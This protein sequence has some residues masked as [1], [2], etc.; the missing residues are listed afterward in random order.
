MDS[1]QVKQALS[2][3][4]EFAQQIVANYER[5][6]LKP[7][8]SQFADDLIKAAQEQPDLIT[9]GDLILGLISP[10]VAGLDTVASIVLFMLYEII[11][12]PALHAR[13]KPE[14]EA[15]FANG[16]PNA[17]QLRQVPILRSGEDQG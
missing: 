9:Q 2:R 1:P 6:E 17:D 14:T 15:L 12:N 7:G 11:R 5:G 10:Y 4:I 16:V 8:D 13:L 3:I